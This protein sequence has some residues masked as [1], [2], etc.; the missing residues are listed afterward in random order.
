MGAFTSRLARGLV[1]ADGGARRRR[2]RVPHRPAAAPRSGG[3]A[4]G[5]RPARR[6]HLLRKHGP[7]LGARRHDQ[8]APGGRRPGARRGVPGGDPP[9]RLAPRPRFRRRRRH[10]RHEAADRRTQGRRARSRCS[11]PGARASPATTSSWARAASARSNSSPRPCSWSGAAAIPDCASRPLSARCGCWR[12]PGTSRAAPRRELAAAYRFL[13]RVE[14]RL[15]MVA[16]RQTHELPRRPAELARFA[17]FMGYPDATALRRRAAAPPR[18][19]PS[20]LCRGV[21]AGAGPAGSQA[22]PDR[23]WTSVASMRRPPPP[24]R[25]CARSASQNPGAIVTAVRGWQAGHVRALRS[26]RARDLLAQM[27]PR[28]LAALGAPAAARHGVQP[29][30]RVSSARLAGRRAAAVAVPAQSARC[31]TASPRCWARRPRW[32]TTWPATP[33]RWTACCRRRTTPDP[34]RLLRARLRGCAPAG[35]RHRDH[36][37]HR[38]RGGFHR[39]GRH[40]GGPAGR[41]RGRAARARR[42]ADA[43][44][45]ALLPPVLADFA[46]RF[47]RVRGGAMAVVALGKAGGREM[48]AGSDLDLMLVYDHPRRRH[49]KPRRRAPAGEPVVRARRARLCRG[50]DRAGRRWPA[51]CGGHAAAAVGQ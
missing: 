10:P 16:D 17:I 20:A 36:P 44:L 1:V 27:L 40:H 11:R 26:A 9:V 30:R 34:A 42:M 23:S 13:R 19:G 4:A 31:S 43:A 14:H 49:R 38:A 33:R 48:M 28:V 35:G 3:H 12:V 50:G 41:R 18:P 22:T 47:G 5:R 39:L 8:G 6:H 45:A 25:R 37:P 24:S 46:S 32:P 7:E 51:L 2:L 29:V 21:R 15:Q